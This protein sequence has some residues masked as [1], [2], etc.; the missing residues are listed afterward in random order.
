M[1]IRTL[2]ELGLRVRDRRLEMGMSQAQ[3]ADRV[4]VSRQWV[5]NLER[6]NAGAALGQVMQV[7][8]IL[9]L[10]MHLR[11]R[12]TGRRTGEP[13]GPRRSVS[14]DDVAAFLDEVLSRT[15]DPEPEDGEPHQRTP[16]RRLEQD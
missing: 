2:L 15:R 13:R 12:R 3:L 7:L 1:R 6:G 8:D 9:K 16:L 11:D 5:V 14:Y 10:D 4:G